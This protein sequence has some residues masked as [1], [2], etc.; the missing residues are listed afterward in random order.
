MVPVAFTVVSLLLT[1]CLQLPKL[2]EFWGH[3]IDMARRPVCL[4]F[5]VETSDISHGDDGYNQTS[6]SV[7]LGTA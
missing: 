2:F 3:C 6:S 5:Q 1:P 7:S 4:E